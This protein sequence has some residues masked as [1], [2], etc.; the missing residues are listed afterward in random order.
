[1][2]HDDYT[3]GTLL[4]PFIAGFFCVNG[5]MWGRPYGMALVVALGLTLVVSV[6]TGF[7]GPALWVTVPFGGMLGFFHAET[8]RMRRTV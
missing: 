8:E 4:I 3:F 6:S 1:M 2:T 5:V 7:G